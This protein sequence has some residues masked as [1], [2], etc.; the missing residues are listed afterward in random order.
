M[1]DGNTF[2][3]TRS[4][5]A[6]SRCARDGPEPA[7]HEYNYVWLNGAKQ[8]NPIPQYLRRL[9]AGHDLHAMIGTQ[10]LT[11]KIHLKTQYGK[12]NVWAPESPY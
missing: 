2:S 1:L 5:S 11:K 8:A 10:P 9:R 4:P 3:D 6:N 7:I 12:L